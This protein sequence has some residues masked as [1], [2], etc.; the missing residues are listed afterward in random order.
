MAK[1]DRPA[2]AVLAAGPGKLRMALVFRE[3]DV[4]KVRKLVE[5]D[6]AVVKG[7][8]HVEVWQQWLANGALA[9][10]R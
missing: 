5:L 3:K 2:V 1:A 9:P 10:A 6:P 7:D 4:E 8:L